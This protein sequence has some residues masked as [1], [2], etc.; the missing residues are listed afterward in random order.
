MAQ[1]A[2]T[3]VRPTLIYKYLSVNG[4]I[5]S[6]KKC[7]VQYTLAS[8]LNDPFECKPQDIFPIDKEDKI[9]KAW[10]ATVDEKAWEDYWR[11]EFG[12]KS[13]TPNLEAFRTASPVD[14]ARN[15]EKIAKMILERE[16]KVLPSHFYIACFSEVHDS[17]LMWTHYTDTHQGIVVGY[18][19]DAPFLN[20][21]EQVRYQKTR[22][23]I[24]FGKGFAQHPKWNHLLATTKH[25]DWAYEKEWR[26][27]F[28]KQPIKG[29]KLPSHLW[30]TLE[31]CYVSAIFLGLQ[32]E[33]PLRNVCKAFVHQ[34]PWCRLYQARMDEKE[35]KIVFD[36][37]QGNP[38]V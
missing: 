1:E 25:Y 21:L 23:C 31:P 12:F 4:G 24:P 8:M 27:I 6:L 35:Y 33:A 5:A 19:T 17:I 2:Q 28:G 32:T 15:I 9:Q 20:C 22:P 29:D 30:I 10:A 34:H 18:R 38:V 37:V 36:L 3:N 11:E 7:T 14:V 13:L 26:C 16:R